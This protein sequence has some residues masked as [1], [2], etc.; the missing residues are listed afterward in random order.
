MS[1]E[2]IVTVELVYDEGCPNV[3]E[4][5]ANL[6]RAFHAAGRQPRWIEWNR[7]DPGSPARVR[8]FGSPAVLINGRDLGGRSPT[9]INRCCRLYRGIDGGLRGAP[10]PELIVSALKKAADAPARFGGRGLLLIPG[11]VF[12]LLPKLAC[13][14]CW[15]AYA[16]VL[17]ALGLSFLVSAEHLFIMMAVFLAIAVGSLA[18]GKRRHH[19]YRP[20]YLGLVASALVL[21]GKFYLSSNLT[22]YLGLGLL[23]AATLWNALPASAGASAKC[24]GC[25][26]GDPASIRKE[27]P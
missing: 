9:E 19:A 10:P 7:S 11:V 23:V 6:L 21:T 5:R 4:A 27:L 17:S 22:L 8:G 26:P 24:A 2:A 3:A 14:A 16:A 15:P 20:F 12:A 25:S 18:F 13:P 1:S